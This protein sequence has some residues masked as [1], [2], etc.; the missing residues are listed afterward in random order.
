MT[1][2]NRLAIAS[3]PAACNCY[4]DPFLQKLENRQLFAVSLNAAGFT[5]VTP[6][7]GDRVVYVSST[8]GNDGNSGLS[9]DAPL[10]SIAAA[11]ALVRAGTGDQLLLRRG[12]RWNESFGVWTKSGRGTASPLVIG[13]YGTG[14]RP[15][16]ATGSAMAITVGSSSAPVVNHLAI[17][18]IR[19]W[20]DA[21]DPSSGSYV[22]TAGNEGVRL[23]SG[24][25]NL[26]V[27]DVEIDSYTTNLVIAGLNGPASNV[28]V[29]RSVIADAY[30]TAGH[31]QGLYADGVNGLTLYQ[32]TFDHNGW[33]TAAGAAQTMFNHN[34]YIKETVSNFVATGNTFARA[35]SHGLQARGG[36]IV[37]S[38]TFI[39]NPIHMSFGM[40]NGSPMKAGGVGGRVWNNAFIGGGSIA[41]APRGFGLELGN[42]KAGAGV[43]VKGNVFAGSP[44]NSGS[45]ISLS[46]G[47]NVTNA[48]SAVGINELTI[49]DNVIYDWTRALTIG[50]EF[51]SGG[52]GST[53]LNNLVIRNNDF[54]RIQ[55]PT[56]MT[57][58]DDFSAAEIVMSGN[59]YH[60]V[61][62]V[63]NVNLGG[64][65][66]S[67]SSWSA[68]R[69][70][71]RIVLVSYPAAGRTAGTY[72]AT[73]N[74]GSTNGAF[75][76]AARGQSSE[77]WDPALTGHQVGDFIR[78]GYGFGPSVPGTSTTP[79]GVESPVSP[80]ASPPPPT[81]PPTTTPKP[82]T[83]KPTTPKPTTPKPTKPESEDDDDKDDDRDDDKE[84]DDHDDDRDD[85]KERLK[86]EEERRRE[87]A[88]KA[89]E[90]QRELLK[91]QAEWKKKA[92]E[93]AKYSG[94]KD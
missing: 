67:W 46:V 33:N 79:S 5:V 22:G 27:E 86:K 49:E 91:K 78:I 47:S 32:N 41:G 52:T 2:R 16:V 28:R 4:S 94:K 13:A 77:T 6:E 9:S 69:D 68:G 63:V 12:D 56:I 25:N 29:R 76:T 30:N 85:E 87:A 54:Q 35:S 8:G 7:A 88:K 17:M 15:V 21:R 26:L 58:G 64:P 61:G 39:D 19:F 14:D 45:A 10:K 75:L 80:P 66:A 20:A 50:N 11:K 1:A 60:A 53:G 31:A 92:A 62:G 38:N 74:L 37:E 43:S 18:G 23:V 57:V 73:L 72:A 34:A 93:K 81:S 89:A 24:T 70:D 65:A 51:V 82:T 42:I 40:V 36:G 59:R 90:K 55:S 44:L 83:P 84:S 71:S 3:A 48:G